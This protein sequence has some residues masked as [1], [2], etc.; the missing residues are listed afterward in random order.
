MLTAADLTFMQ[1]TQDEA[2][3]GTVVIQRYALTSDGMGGQYETWAAA[4]TAIGRIYIVPSRAQNEPIGGAQVH[5]HARWVGTFP[6]GTDVVA[7]DRLAYNGRT[8]EV[9]ST[10]NDQM[11][12]TAVRCELES[13]NEESRV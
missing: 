6:I 11:W 3:P 13:H 5:S 4:G 2:L 10:N 9:T 7:Q 8:W 1:E 12:Q